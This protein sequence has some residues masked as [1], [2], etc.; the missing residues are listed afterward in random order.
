[1]QLS[2]QSYRETFE[3]AI[4]EHARFL[5]STKEVMQLGTSKW[6]AKI[7]VKGLTLWRFHICGVS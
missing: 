1:M 3:M 5:E 2:L 6:F 4:D 7:I